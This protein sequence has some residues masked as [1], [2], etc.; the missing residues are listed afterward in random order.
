M[1]RN[2]VLDAEVR[3]GELL[4][5]IPSE[6]SH[7][8]ETLKRSSTNETPLSQKQEA[9]KEAGISKAQA[10]RFQVMAEHPDIVEKAKAEAK[11]S[12]KLFVW[13]SVWDIRQYFTHNNKA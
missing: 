6:S 13:E 1:V 2:A 5:E 11:E 4:N 12:K 8:G 7:K 3:I 9:R 10:F